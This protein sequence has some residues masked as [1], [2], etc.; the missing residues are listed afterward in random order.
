ME[1]GDILL[2]TWTLYRTHWRHL[3]TIAAVVYVPLGAVAAVLA[4]GGW[5]GGVAA[6]L[7]NVAAIFCV[8]GALVKAVED[9]GDGLPDMGIA[10]TY[11]HVGDRLATLALAGV[12]AT[13][14]IAAGLVLLIV[15]GLL[16]LT[17]WLVLAPVIMLECRRTL[18]AFRRSREL[19]TQSP[20]PVFGVA[21]LTLLALLVFS[22]LLTLAVRPL[23][24][25]AGAF[26]LTAVGS[27]LAAPFAAV[28]WTLTYF[29][30]RG[31]EGAPAG[32]AAGPG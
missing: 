3:V 12:L 27:S 25:P 31:I 15:P 2:R 9:V 5:A 21:V 7:L 4:L 28:A 23:S 6:N 30:L 16:L 14:S 10:E 26:L 8:H 1:P 24:D 18:D 20:W 19:V 17:W 32:G 13:L 22:A 11:G 29:G